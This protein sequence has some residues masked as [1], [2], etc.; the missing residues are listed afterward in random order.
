M[1]CSWLEEIKY[2][3][4]GRNFF[5]S[6]ENQWMENYLNM[7]SEY[8]CWG[9]GCEMMWTNGTEW[10]ASLEWHRLSE[11]FLLNKENELVNFYFFVDLPDYYENHSEAN[12]IDE[13]PIQLGL[14]LWYLHPHKGCSRGAVLLD[15]QED[16][17]PEIMEYL[18]LAQERHQERFS[19]L[20]FLKG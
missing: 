12:Y 7:N 4:A 10:N 2:Y 16:N 15:I 18:K 20:H 14:Q 5:D 6:P 3:E 13:F 9:N 19:R 11:L 8:T 17:M 1:W